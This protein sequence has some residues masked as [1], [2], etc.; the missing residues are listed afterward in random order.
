V[1]GPWWRYDARCP[2]MAAAAA[3]W[4]C[5]NLELFL[6]NWALKFQKSANMT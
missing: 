3:S 6:G 2:W 5:S 4:S 1:A